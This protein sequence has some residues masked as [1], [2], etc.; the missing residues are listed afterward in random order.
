MTTDATLAADVTLTR[1]LPQA[2]AL[3]G[4]KLHLDL[5]AAM[6]GEDLTLS[7]LALHG[8]DIDLAGHGAFASATQKLVLDWQLALA[9]SPMSPPGDRRGRR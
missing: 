1:A 6:A 2:M 5:A 4:G 3:T 9:A 8:A 7:K